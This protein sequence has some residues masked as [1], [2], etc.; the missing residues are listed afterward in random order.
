MDNELDRLTGECRY[1]GEVREVEKAMDGPMRPQP[2]YQVEWKAPGITVRGSLF[3]RFKVTL[4][5]SERFSRTALRLRINHT[6]PCRDKA[7]VLSKGL[8]GGIVHPNTTKT[9][10]RRGESCSESVS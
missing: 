7:H 10:R 2:H 9:R 5:T 4:K 1:I 3:T 8:A 6:M